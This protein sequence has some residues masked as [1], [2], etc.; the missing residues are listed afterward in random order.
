MNK[1]FHSLVLIPTLLYGSL[2]RQAPAISRPILGTVEDASGAAVVG[3]SV[4][5]E[6]P[7]GAEIMHTVTDGV[8]EFQFKN[9]P[10]GRY[11]VDVRQNGF[12]ETKANV[13]A[14]SVSHPSAR[15]VLHMSGRANRRRSIR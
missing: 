8:G 9:V 14:D 5:L 3:A 13:M 6:R 1:L 15:I 11:L 7:Y 10:R 12:K 4:A 2:P